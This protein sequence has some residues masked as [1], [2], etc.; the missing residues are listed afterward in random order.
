MD[1]PPYLNLPGSLTFAP[2]FS[3]RGVNQQVFLLRASYER[4]ISVTDRWLNAVPNSEYRFV[5][6]LP[7][8]L[9]SPVWIDRI[10]SPSW[11]GGW[12]HESEIDFA[13]FVACFRNGQL[14]HIAM[15]IPYL[16]VDNGR[17]VAEGREIYGYRKVYGEMDYVAGT[18]QPGAAS[19]G[20]FKT[21]LPDEEWQQAEVA[22]IIT[23]PGYA[24]AVRD[25]TWEDIHAIEGLVA[26]TLV[27][28]IGLAIEHLIA[29]FRSQS[30]TNAYVLQVRDVQ[31]PA[32]AGYQALIEAPMQITNLV[33]FRF[34]PDGFAV[35]LTD[36]PSYPLISDLGIEVDGNNI[37]ASVLSYQT[38]YDAVLQPG[39][40]L[41]VGGRTAPA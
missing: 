22:R 18:W 27:V 38:F 10:I 33:S 17:A 13:Y 30:L 29:L 39:N 26:S 19:T 24:A 25:A 23:P 20:V 9:C 5:P 34:L 12:M 40:V 31:Y 4:L 1:L 15:A 7:F 36:F 2:P 32:S 37:A 11:P 6:L 28:D 35:K 14:D 16:I 21:S 3:F 8:V 41:A